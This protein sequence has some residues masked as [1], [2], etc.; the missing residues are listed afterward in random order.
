MTGGEKILE[1]LR[2]AAIG[3]FARVTIAGQV[4]VRHDAGSPEDLL[5]QARDTITD[6]YQRL[7]AKD[8]EIVDAVVSE[9]E[10][11]A[12][13]AESMGGDFIE[14]D[15]EGNGYR[16]ARNHI[17][18]AIRARARSQGGGIDAQS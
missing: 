12:R 3:S 7:D 17:A 6:L 13:V 14:C 18:A 9:R 4:W 1:G 16:E 8:A 2:E 5:N 11:C 10:A 15:A